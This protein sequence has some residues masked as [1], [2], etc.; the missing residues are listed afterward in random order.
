M[1]IELDFKFLS[2]N[3]NNKKPKPLFNP[4]QKVNELRQEINNFEQKISELKNEIISINKQFKKNIFKRIY[5][6]FLNLW[7][8]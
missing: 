6:F 8:R 4:E 5:Q 7:R 2:N 3:E 1:V